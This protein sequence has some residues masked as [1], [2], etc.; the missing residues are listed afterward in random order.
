M[1]AHE[2]MSRKV[3]TA[4]KDTTVGEIARLMS[5]ER[6]SGVPVVDDDGH[7]I[8]MISETDLMHR[9]EIGTERRRKWWV[10]L[11]VD[12]DMR[13]RDFT[14]AHGQQAQHVMSRYVISVPESAKLAEV[15]DILETNNL[16]RVP[17][18]KAGR[19]VGIITRG[20]LVRALAAAD[21]ARVTPTSD[22]AT[23]QKALNERIARQPWAR[24]AFLNA[25]VGE[26]SV[27]LRGF[28]ASED[29]R[30]ALLVLAREVAGDRPVDDHLRVGTDLFKAA[31]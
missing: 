29:Q 18:L 24:S 5:T 10:S 6:I 15:A 3:H 25:V 16:K 20:D 31:A 13:A 7:V 2:I 17:V 22:S 27:E 8:G 14:K 26:R 19:L 12:E 23:L 4:G 9:P 28:V 30:N 21:A 1:R 11:F